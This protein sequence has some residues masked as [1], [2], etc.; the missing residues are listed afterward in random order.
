MV[1][2]ISEATIR[3]IKQAAEELEYRPNAVARAL[4]QRRTYT[5]GLFSREMTDPH[6]AQMLEYVE[7]KARAMGYHLVVSGEL[8]GIIGHGRVDGIIVL[9]SPEDPLSRRI[10]HDTKVVYVWS[11]NQQLPNCV[12]W[13]DE[14]GSYQAGKY[15]VELGH[16]RIAA[17][18][19]D[20]EESVRYDKAEGFRRAMKEGGVYW[21][22]YCCEAVTDMID[23]G[24]QLGKRL[25]ADREGITAIFARND[26]LAV[27]AVKALQQMGVA[28]PHDISL[29]GY[30]DTILAR[31]TSPELTSVRTPIGQAGALAVERLVEALEKGVAHFP[32]IML[33]TSLTIRQSCSPPMH[34]QLIQD[35]KC[36]VKEAD[37]NTQREG[38]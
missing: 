2:P 31:S 9:A 28:I 7:A 15:L 30:A 21:R 4:V 14:E 6:F 12:S 37:L 16:R 10:G 3:R 1:M 18:F 24:Y 35:D 27:G 29:V 32:G 23:A 36:V 26:F 38:G 34:A 5:I 17:L 20:Y 13:N 22:E 8:E 33:P 19:G 11:S 25:L